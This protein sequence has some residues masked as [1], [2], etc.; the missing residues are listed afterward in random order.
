[1]TLRWSSRRPGSPWMGARFFSTRLRTAWATL[2]AHRSGASKAMTIAPNPVKRTKPIAPTQAAWERSE[3]TGAPKITTGR[4]NT[5]RA[6]SPPMPRNEKAVRPLTDSVA[7]IPAVPSI[8]NWTAAPAAAPPGTMS[9]MALPDSWAVI[10]AN[11]A[12]VRRA[13]RWRAKVQAKWAP[14]AT[15][16]GMNHSRLRVARRGHE[17]RTDRMLGATR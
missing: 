6:R 1:M 15:T 8:R 16:A 5:G 9:E 4:T 12:L 7:S 14:S 13:M 17:C 10:T 3:A 2:P 11:Q